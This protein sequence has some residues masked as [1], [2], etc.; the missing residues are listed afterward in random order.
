MSGKRSADEAPPDGNVAATAKASKHDGHSN[1]KLIVLIDMD[2]TIVEFDRRA[3][4]LLSARHPSIPSIDFETRTFPLA[5]SYSDD[6]AK[7]ALA[8]LFTEPS[9]FTEMEP[10]KGAVDALHAMVAAGHDVRLCSSPLAKSPRCAMEKIEWIVRHLGQSWVDRLVLTRDKTLVRGHIL[11][12][13]APSAKGSALTPTWEH[14]YYDQPYNR[15]GAAGAEP[16]R[17]RL[18]AWADWRATLLS[19]EPRQV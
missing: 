7:A 14:V 16:S 6:R 2:G 12:D 17:R 13:D 1:A 3:L 11:I 19:T 5:K 10:V 9:F 4:E 8:A 15:P 18:T